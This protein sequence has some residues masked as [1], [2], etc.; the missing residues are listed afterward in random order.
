[1]LRSLLLFAGVMSWMIHTPQ[2]SAADRGDS[3][4]RI[5]LGVGA[6]SIDFDRGFSEGD[7]AYSVFAAYEFNRYLS[8]E[9]G[10][11]DGGSPEDRGVSVDLSNT[12]AMA[13]GSLPLVGDVWSVSARA[14]VIGWFWE[15]LGIKHEG[16]D[17]A[18]GVGT[19]I[20]LRRV[21]LRIICDTAEID[22]A[23]LVHLSLQGAWKF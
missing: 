10:Y 17:F 12:T 9:V 7:T 18:Y 4:F 1:M 23:R 2:A 13:V 5:G 16:N 20:D 14:G 15:S 3:G 11:V 21:Q 22:D 8:A 19:A 6:D